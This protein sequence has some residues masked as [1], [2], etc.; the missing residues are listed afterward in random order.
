MYKRQIQY[1][2][3]TAGRLSR[4]LFLYLTFLHVRTVARLL[5]VTSSESIDRLSL[6]FSSQILLSWTITPPQ[7]LLHIVGIIIN[8]L[9]KKMAQGMICYRPRARNHPKVCLCIED[10]RSRAQYIARCGLN[11]RCGSYREPFNERLDPRQCV[12]MWLGS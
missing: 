1:V 7:C 8:F 5:R 9:F 11:V 4:F 6:K 10:S 2:Q 12:P 3:Q